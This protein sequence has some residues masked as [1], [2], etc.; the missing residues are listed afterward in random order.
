[1]IKNKYKN[2]RLDDNYFHCH[3]QINEMSEK[4]ALLNSY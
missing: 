1:M 4:D 2:K 3:Y